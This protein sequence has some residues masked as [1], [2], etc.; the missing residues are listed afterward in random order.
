MFQFD[1]ILSKITVF[2]TVVLKHIIHLKLLNYESLTLDVFEHNFE[3]NAIDNLL[4]LYEMS[5]L[6]NMQIIHIFS[7]CV[8]I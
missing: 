7:T 5:H 6:K 8:S 1:K 3:R 4:V 2:K